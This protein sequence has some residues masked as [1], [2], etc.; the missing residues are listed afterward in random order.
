KNEGG[1]MESEI[2]LSLFARRLHSIQ[3]RHPDVV[4]GGSVSLG[5]SLR[6]Q[7]L[8]KRM[9]EHE[10]AFL[11]AV[12]EQPEDDL[13]RLAWADWLDDHGQ[14]ERAAFMRAQ[15]RAAA[16]PEEDLARDAAEDEAD[17]L[18]AVHEVEWAGRV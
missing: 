1:A 15:L 17:D 11:E 13:H 14:A 18:L 10:R 12:Q 6:P 3:E 4:S 2:A 16:L 7:P 9:M 8:S 5:E